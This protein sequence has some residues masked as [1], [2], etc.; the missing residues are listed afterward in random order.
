MFLHYV[1]VCVCVFSVPACILSGGGDC[2]FVSPSCF[3][4]HWDASP[5]KECVQSEALYGNLKQIPS[6][7]IR[8]THDDLV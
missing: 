3:S 2:V 4:L 1:C 8:A 7:F 6:A 5:N